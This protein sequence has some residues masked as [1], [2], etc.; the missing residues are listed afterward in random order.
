MNAIDIRISDQALV[1]RLAQLA[2]LHKRSVEAEALALIRSALAG[3]GPVDR[4]AIARSI[5]A[6]T[7]KDRRQSDSTAM[8]REDRDRDG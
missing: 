8:I 2:E 7:P 4:L 5:S 6:M 1:D 3:H